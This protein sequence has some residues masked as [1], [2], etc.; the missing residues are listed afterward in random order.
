MLLLL[1]VLKLRYLLECCKN[2]YT[3]L[4]LSLWLQINIFCGK[5]KCAPHFSPIGNVYLGSICPVYVQCSTSDKSREVLSTLDCFKEAKTDTP[6]SALPN[7]KEK[8]K[9]PKNA[10]FCKKKER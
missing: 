3:T 8:D 2:G 4:K 10:S 5:A 6:H 7:K 1:Y 9:K